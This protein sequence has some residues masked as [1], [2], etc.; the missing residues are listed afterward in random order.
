M[1]VPCSH[2]ARWHHRA[3]LALTISILSACSMADAPKLLPACEGE[4]CGADGDRFRGGEL[5]IWEYRNDTDKPQVLPI[6][7]EGLYRSQVMVSLTNM[8]DGEVDMPVGLRGVVLD[9]PA[10]ASPASVPMPVAIPYDPARP[11]RDGGPEAGSNPE[12]PN[13]DTA[14]I[15]QAT[16]ASLAKTLL[17]HQRVVLQKNDVSGMYE[18][19]LT[20]PSGV[21]VRVYV[22]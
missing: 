21:R 14:L 12:L 2:I 13:P 4:R 1:T 17:P 7:L 5:G 11:G 6:A 3:A 8:T 10:E 19:D 15:A 20:V 18:R 16:R 22:R 9:V